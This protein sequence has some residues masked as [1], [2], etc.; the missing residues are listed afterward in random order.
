MKSYPMIFSGDSILKIL[1]GTKTQ[2]RRVV[3]FDGLAKRPAGYE[4]CVVT[5][6]DGKLFAVW[7]TSTHP[8]VPLPRN[9]PMVGDRIWAKESWAAWGNAEGSTLYRA[10]C[11]RDNTRWGS[12]IFMPRARSRLTLEVTNVRVQQL[13][14]I[15]YRDVRDEGVTEGSGEDSVY[16]FSHAWDII[17]AK[18]GHSWDSNPWV[19]ART[20][21]VVS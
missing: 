8:V 6:D 19:L 12:P 21:R 9:G 3:R 7:P 16:I 4:D 1:A 2:T 15:T 13:Q 20:F 10:D 5:V 17:N 11:E 18:R 14:Y